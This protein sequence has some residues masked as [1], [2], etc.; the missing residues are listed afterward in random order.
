MY[1]VYYLYLQRTE[2]FHSQTKRGIMQMKNLIIA[3]LIAVLLTYSCGQIASE[4]FDISIRMDDQLLSPFESLAGFTI[5]GVV[6]VI[7]GFI[8]AVSV[9]GVVMFAVFAVFGGIL[10]AGLAAFWPAILVL[11]LVVW[12]VKDKK[13]AYH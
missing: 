7:L 4:W 12:L 8:L 1:W 13:P 2:G 5:A 11:V 9:F 10:I 3:I 6:L